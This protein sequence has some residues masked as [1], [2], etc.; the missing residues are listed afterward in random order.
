MAT[1]LVVSGPIPT[2]LSAIERLQR[3]DAAVEEKLA[4]F[5]KMTVGFWIGTAV[6]FILTVFFSIHLLVVLLVPCL[7]VAIFSTVRRSYFAGEDI[8]NRRLSG[9]QH[10]LEILGNDVPR[11]G[12]CTLSLNFDGYLKHG[13]LVS[14][15]GSFLTGT[16]AMYQDNWLSAKGI[17]CDGSVFRFGIDQYVSR[18]ERK[19]RKYTK[20]AERKLEKLNLSLKVSPDAYPEWQQ[21][22]TL[23]Q[24]GPV[25]SLQVTR[26]NVANNTIRV[27]AVTPPFRK[28]T[29]R[30]GTQVS[31]SEVLTD[32]DMMLQLFVYVYAQLQ[33]CMGKQP[34]TE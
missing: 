1:P 12:K 24:P 7:G 6:F 14:K 19:K 13:K 2:I 28:V 15:S 10:F 11:K 20:V 5:T 34:V 4:F 32:G 27:T 16:Q 31:G 3:Y 25:N 33:Q 26:V 8:E 9:P 30:T 18:K 21:L 23:L 29:G 22:A 17:L